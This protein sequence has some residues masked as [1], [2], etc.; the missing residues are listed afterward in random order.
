MNAD[1]LAAP[2]IGVDPQCKRFKSLRSEKISLQPRSGD[3]V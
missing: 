3:V 2:L 1:S